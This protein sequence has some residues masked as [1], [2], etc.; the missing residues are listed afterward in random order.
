MYYSNSMH[1][2]WLGISWH[3]HSMSWYPIRFKPVQSILHKVLDSVLSFGFHCRKV[4][5]R[6]HGPGY[7]VTHWPAR[8]QPFFPLQEMFS[9]AVSGS[10]SLF[11]H[12]GQSLMTFSPFH[13]FYWPWSKTI[14]QGPRVCQCLYILLMTR[15][16]LILYCHVYCSQLLLSSYIV[17]PYIGR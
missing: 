3:S 5:S 2:K 15:N 17:L 4:T 6:I 13:P 7:Y 16:K 9:K 8:I 1:S 14:S 12:L 10:F 11:L